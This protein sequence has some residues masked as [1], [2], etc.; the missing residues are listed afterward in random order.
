MKIFAIIVTY[1]GYKW[2]DRCFRSLR[3]SSIPIQIIVI[4]NAS[5]DD[6][7]SY[8]K[9]NYSEVILVESDKNLGFGKANNIGLK[10][11]LE[12]G[13]DY[14]FLLNQDA[15]VM[16]DTIEKLCYQMQ[17]HPEYGILSP[18]HLNGTEKELDLNF[19][20]YI[21]AQS[22]PYLISDCIV[23]GKS[24][25]KIYPV[26]FVNAALWLVSKSCMEKIGGFCPLFPH[27]GEDSDY[28]ARLSYH[29]LKIGIYPLVYGVH[30]RPQGFS[31]MNKLQ[32]E[33]QYYISLLVRLCNINNSFFYSF[34]VLFW[35]FFLRIIHMQITLTYIK[36]WIKL[37]CSITKIIRHRKIAKEKNPIYIS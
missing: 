36:N 10:Y 24:K 35:S 19:S 8:I 12:R 25:D 13:F 2:Y 30:D 34:S 20:N 4:D 9:K 15:W 33:K 37:F 21:N 1:N 3:N 23:S 32:Y 16:P 18:I 26:E 31:E 14:V 5:T 22:C 7:V 27:Y 6:T 28:V 17:Q 29:K 11:V